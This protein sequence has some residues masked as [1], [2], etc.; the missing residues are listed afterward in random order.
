MGSKEW[1]HFGGAE[2]RDEVQIEFGRWLRE[3]WGGGD[4]VIDLG[5]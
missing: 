3:G 1:W 4:E 5:L 2:R